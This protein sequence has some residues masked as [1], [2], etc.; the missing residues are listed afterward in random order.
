MSSRNR[1]GDDY[2]LTEFAAAAD[3]DVDVSVEAATDG[4]VGVTQP[5]Q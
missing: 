4:T 3:L 1:S 5:S 2:L